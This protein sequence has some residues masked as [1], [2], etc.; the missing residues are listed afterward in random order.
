MRCSDS[1]TRHDDH[2][3]ST[4]IGPHSIPLRPAAVAND[5]RSA[6]SRR[7]RPRDGS[8]RIRV[9]VVSSFGANGASAYPCWPRP[10]RLMSGTYARCHT[11]VKSGLPLGVLGGGP[12]G[13]VYRLPDGRLVYVAKK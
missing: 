8:E 3:S 12:V 2:D 4:A 5:C 6:R 9:N 11:P 13:T 1:S 10:L 7:A